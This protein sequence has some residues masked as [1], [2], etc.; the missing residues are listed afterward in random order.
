MFRLDA[1]AFMWKRMGTDCQGQPEV[2]AITQALRAVTRIACPAVAFKAEAIVAPSKLLAYLGQGR[3]TGKVSDLAYHN[4]LMVQVWSMLA[5]RDVRLAA[6]A[7]SIFGD[8]SDVMAARMTGWA[9]LCASSVQEAHDMALIAQNATLASRIPFI[10]FFDG[11][12]T[13]HE[14]AKIEVLDDA[15]HG[16][17]LHVLDEGEALDAVDL[18]LEHRVRL[19]DDQADLVGGERDVLRLGAVAVEHRGDL[20]G[21]TGA[22][23]GA[24]AELGALLDGNSY[25]GHGGVL[26][27]ASGEM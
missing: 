1:I 18:E 10:H 15:E 16:V 24:L 21:A 17:L 12:R 3:Y 23:R 6:Q 25:L 27:V 7:L 13:S 2:H 5:T 11:F 9:M 19:A 26:L 14:V 22:A 4:S 20:A 8:H